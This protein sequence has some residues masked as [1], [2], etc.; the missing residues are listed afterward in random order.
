MMFWMT[1]LRTSTV[2]SHL[3]TVKYG[4]NYMFSNSSIIAEQRLDTPQTM[5]AFPP[6]PDCP[7]GL[8]D[9]VVISPSSDSDWLWQGIECKSI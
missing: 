3:I 7:Y 8:Y 1:G 9:T 6:S 4:T 2:P 5:R